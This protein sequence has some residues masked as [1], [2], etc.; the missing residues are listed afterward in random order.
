MFCALPDLGTLRCKHVKLL[1]RM[2]C[3]CYASTLEGTISRRNE[4]SVNFKCRASSTMT[5]ERCPWDFEYVFRG[6]C[7]PSTQCPREGDEVH[8]MLVLQHSQE[9]QFWIVRGKV[10]YWFRFLS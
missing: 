5:P 6:G 2:D 10:A 7:L 1:G 4:L 3:I 8:E 9:Q